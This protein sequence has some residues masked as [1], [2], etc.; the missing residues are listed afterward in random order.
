MKR[1]RT[2]PARTPLTLNHD[3]AA[4]TDTPQTVS[5]TDQNTPPPPPSPLPQ[6]TNTSLLRTTNV[7]HMV[8]VEF[9]GGGFQVGETVSPLRFHY[10]LSKLL[11]QVTVQIHSP[12]GASAASRR[13]RAHSLT[14][15]V[16]SPH[17]QDH[18]RS[19]EDRAGRPV[20][21]RARPLLR[22]AV[23]GSICLSLRLLPVTAKRGRGLAR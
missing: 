8:V 19:S 18:L 16:K 21:H 15:S 5:F 11:L 12:E 6:P 9:G 13:R 14:M 3:L 4:F 17:T 2:R 22:F 20:V 23:T 1:L 7:Q 10:G